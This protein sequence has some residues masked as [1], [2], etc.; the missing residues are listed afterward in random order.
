MKLRLK[1]S[2]SA[3]GYIARVKQERQK[4][5]FVYDMG[6][7]LAAGCEVVQCEEVGFEQVVFRQVRKV[8]QRVS[9]FQLRFY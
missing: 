3:G 4:H 2:V 8:C 6:G 7:S 9:G 1:R 5:E